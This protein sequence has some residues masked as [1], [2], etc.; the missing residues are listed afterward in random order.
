[1]KYLLSMLIGM[2]AGASLM[3]WILNH[4]NHDEQQRIALEWLNTHQEWRYTLCNVSMDAD[5]EAK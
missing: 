4:P 2:L 1:M 5:K 3:L